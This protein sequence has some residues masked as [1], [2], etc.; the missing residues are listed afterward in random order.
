MI[1]ASTGNLFMDILVYLNIY[2]IYLL[3]AFFPATYYIWIKIFSFPLVTRKAHELLLVATPEKIHI[4]KIKSRL[5]PFFSFRKGL[6]WFSEPL[7][8]IDSKNQYHVYIEGINQALSDMERRP[9]KMDELTTFTEK[10]NEVTSHSI[11]FPT[12]LKLHMHRHWLIT[13]EPILHKL[14]L[15]PVKERQSLRFSFY[16]TVGIQIQSQIESEEELESDAGSNKVM[17]TNLTS[18]TIIKKIKYIQEYSYFSSSYAFSLLRKIRRAN[19][20]FSRWVIGGIDPK[21]LL[22][23]IIMFGSIAMI[24]FLIPMMTPKLGE[25]PV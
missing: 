21:L 17:L 22:I 2:G 12:K 8:D 15:E 20:N 16:H 3:V 5:Q 13:L 24:Y 9:N 4:K 1:E 19:M 25:M 23:L 10:L 11:K 6:Y 18:Q 7:D 14:K